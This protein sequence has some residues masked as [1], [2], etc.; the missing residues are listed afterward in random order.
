MKSKKLS[1]LLKIQ[2]VVFAVIIAAG[3]CSVGAFAYNCSRVRSDVLR[4]HVIANSDSDED[5][6]LK[7]K[8]RDA[9]LE[10][11]AELFDGTVTAD[12][13]YTF[14]GT[15]TKDGDTVVLMFPTAGTA[16]ENWGPLAG[17]YF[18]N[19]ENASFADSDYA[20]GVVQCKEAESHLIAD[21]FE[22][23]YLLDNLTTSDAAF[24]AEECTVTI[25]VSGDTFD[26]V[27]TNSDDD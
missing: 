22:G 13:V 9:V 5:Q 26:Y 27:I 25:T 3:A 4:M 6:A 15:Y 16:S 14:T 1:K 2:A 21:L 11:G 7:L 23:P 19:T 12:L 17:S 8:V 20:A 24:D 18:Q 10:R